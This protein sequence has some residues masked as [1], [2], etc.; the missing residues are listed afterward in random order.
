LYPYWFVPTS[1]A[2]QEFLTKI[3]KDTSW[4]DRQNMQVIEKAGK[5]ID[6]KTLP[7]SQFTATN[8]AYTI[9]QATGCD[10]TLGTIKLDV[11]TPFGVYL[12]DTNDKD[13]F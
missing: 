5:I 4:L 8:F 13:F 10:N 2:I 9:R 11:K 12:H 1:I 3:I 7:W 6:P